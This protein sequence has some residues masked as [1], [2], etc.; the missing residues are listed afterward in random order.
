MATIQVKPKI[1][2]LSQE[3]IL[4][5]AWKKAH[6]YIRYH[7]WYSD[8]LELDLTNAD[9]ERCLKRI[10][11]ELQSSEELRSEPLRLVLAP[12]SQ[13]WEIRDND[14][15][16]V[17]GT[18]SVEKKLRPLAH[19]S[20]R[21]QII[22]TAF[23]ILLADTVETRQGDPTATA[24]RAR[25]RRMVSYGHR[26]FCDM[27]DRD[28][29]FRWGNSVVY[30]QYFQDY[31]AFISRP[32]EIVDFVFG[33]SK[34]WAIVSADLSQFYDRVRPDALH[35]KIESMVGATADLELMKKF[36]GFFRWSWHPSDQ[37]QARKYAETPEPNIAGFDQVALPQGLVASGFFSNA[38]LLDF[39]EA[40]CNE[41]DNWNDDN[42]WQLVDFCRY[43][44]DMR[45]VIR[46]ADK[47]SEM[48]QEE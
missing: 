27:E 2:F 14:W 30:R 34:N 31:L 39:D 26:L 36:R 43:V 5:Q 19:A 8:V 20:A 35:R 18:R 6:D 32:Q 45:I 28:L 1:N 12:K 24:V 41:F 48:K 9:L 22:G 11:Q 15:V 40:V 33:V 46:L 38:F 42:Q 23:L 3:Y 16:P 25:E 13:N 17:E 10:S 7:N 44:D 4:V 37:E 21:D 29:R 47:S